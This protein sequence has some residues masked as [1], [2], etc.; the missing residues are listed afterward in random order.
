MVDHQKNVLFRPR[1][2]PFNNMIWLRNSNVLHKLYKWI[3]FYKIR[4]YK[5]N[6][7]KKKTDECYP[8][9]SLLKNIQ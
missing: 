9:L 4:C 6:F 1:S 7:S 2:S 8:V 3:I 5:N